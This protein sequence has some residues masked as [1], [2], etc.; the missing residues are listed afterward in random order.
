MVKDQQELLTP[1]FQVSSQVTG[2][3][4]VN[5]GKAV[6]NDSLIR[7]LFTDHDQACEQT[8]DIHASKMDHIFGQTN[9]SPWHATRVR[10]SEMLVEG[11]YCRVQLSVPQG[12]RFLVL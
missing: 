4:V 2:N 8:A 1:K 7:H 9:L 5:L 10:P 11:V 3:P 12:S 6:Q